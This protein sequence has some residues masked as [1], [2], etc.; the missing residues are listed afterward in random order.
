MTTMP[1]LDATSFTSR[2]GSFGLG[3]KDGAPQLLR[4]PLPHNAR[5]ALEPAS[6][7]QCSPSIPEWAGPLDI[8]YP[9]GQAAEEGTKRPGPTAVLSRI[10]LTTQLRTNLRRRGAAEADRW[11]TPT[12]ED[13]PQAWN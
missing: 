7:A 1:T 3:P 10:D 13:P 11:T 2:G 6:A 5:S 12:Q 8:R 9:A 4:P